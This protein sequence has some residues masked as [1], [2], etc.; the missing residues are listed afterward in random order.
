MN[1]NVKFALI[2]G[3]V[4]LALYLVNQTAQGV[5]NGAESAGSSIGSGIG[6][7]A[8]LAGGGIGIGFA[9][10]PFLLLL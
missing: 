8:E 4:I 10:L 1:E 7:G 2:G 5:S 9:A 3:G 6:T